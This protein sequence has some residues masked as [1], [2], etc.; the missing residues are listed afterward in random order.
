MTFIN[1]I[2]AF[3]RRRAP[4]AEA[5]YMVWR[6]ARAL[7]RIRSIY[8]NDTHVFLMRGATGDTWLQ[9]ALMDNLIRERGISAY[10]IVGDSAGCVELARLFREENLIPAGGYKAACIE[11]AYMLLGGERLRLTLLFPWTY[12]LYFN[13]CRIRMTERFDFMDTYRYYVL[14]LKGAMRIKIP[15]FEPITPEQERALS[16]RGFV[17]GRTVVI[18]PEANSVT[19]LD[20]GLWN[21]VIAGLREKGYAVVVNTKKKKAYHAPDYFCGYAQSVPLLE[22]AGFFVGLRS[23]FCDIV[24]SAKCRKVI[25]YPAKASRVNYSEHRTEREFCGLK[26]MGLIWEQDDTLTE[27]DTALVRNITDTEDALGDEE[28]RAREEELLIARLLS[29][30]DGGA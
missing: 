3:V 14:N 19:E 27:L 23:G 2:K 12:A 25:L 9:L 11:K 29:A 10:K 21:R 4:S 8:G 15:E 16:E 22:Y 18:A 30:F 1:L 28:E 5:L 17:R 26:K 24:S 7:K 6:G 13:R 20:A